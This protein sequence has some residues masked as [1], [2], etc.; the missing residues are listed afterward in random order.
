[1]PMG[2]LATESGHARPTLCSA[3][4]RHE[5]KFSVAPKLLLL[6]HRLCTLGILLK[7]CGEILEG[8]FL[9]ANVHRGG[10]G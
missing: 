10:G 6:V 3:P 1:M 7:F 4:H 5:R 2:V 8:D 9:S